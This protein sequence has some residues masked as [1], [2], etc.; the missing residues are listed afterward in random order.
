MK[1]EHVRNVCRIG[2]GSNCCSF[3]LNG[4]DSWECAKAPGNEGFLRFLESRRE[5]RKLVA[6]ADNCGGPPNFTP[7]QATARAVAPEVRK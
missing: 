1:L 4:G 3:L 6:I 2:A 7:T 5:Q